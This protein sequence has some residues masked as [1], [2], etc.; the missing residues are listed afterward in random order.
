VIGTQTAEASLVSIDAVRAMAVCRVSPL[1]PASSTGSFVPVLIAG[2]AA[3]R[4]F[5]GPD[6]AGDRA[7]A[8]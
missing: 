6:A 1:S 5:P 4:A 2:I 7:R 8:A 3:A